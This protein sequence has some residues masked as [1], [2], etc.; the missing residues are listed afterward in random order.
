MSLS[1][2]SSSAVEDF[3]PPC[4]FKLASFLKRM[5]LGKYKIFQIQ[6][7]CKYHLYNYNILDMLHH[8]TCRAHFPFAVA[9]KNF[10]YCGTIIKFIYNTR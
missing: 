6:K 8:Y 3:R 2:Y 5:T 7:C 4:L 1:K 9:Q 10:C